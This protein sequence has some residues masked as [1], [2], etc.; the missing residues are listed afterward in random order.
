MKA[1][2]LLSITTKLIYIAALC[3]LNVL[4]AYLFIKLWK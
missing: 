1:L 3:M 4:F 2:F